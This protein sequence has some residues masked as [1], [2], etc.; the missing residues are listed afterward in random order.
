[1]NQI[2]DLGDAKFD[3]F[4]FEKCAVVMQDPGEYHW[5]VTCQKQS[6]NHAITLRDL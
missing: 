5:H 6:D 2:F 4:E 1:M 3:V